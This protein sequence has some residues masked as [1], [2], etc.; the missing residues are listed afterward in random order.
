MS[1]GGTARV[2]LAALV[3]GALAGAGAVLL[4]SRGPERTPTPP[5]PL[6][7]EERSVIDT[8]RRVAPSVVYITTLDVRRDVFTLDVTAVPR[9][10]GSGFV[11]DA[12]GHIVTNFHVVTSADA[13]QV[14]LA[15][16]TS[17]P[18]RIV[19]LAPDV[20]LAV[21]RID[22]PRE[23]LSPIL[24]GTSQDLQVGQRALAI[25]NP[26]GLDHSLTVGVISALERTIESVTGREIPGVV[27]TDASINPGNSGGPLLD[28]AGRLI[29]VSTA[30]QSPSG[31]SA[32]I[33]FAVPVDTVR[34]VVPQLIEHGRVIRPRIGLRVAGDS[35]N[36][37][38]GLEGL[39]VLA[40][41]P[42]GPADRAGILGSGRDRRGRIILGDELLALGGQAL[43][44]ADHLTL[45]LEAHDVGA[46][47]SVRLRRGGDVR[48]VELTLAAP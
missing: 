40:V 13:L 9:G 34:R 46:T 15:D 8:F 27:Q 12:S 18:A 1:R 35:L 19:G 43:R 6:G 45:A 36:R 10:T 3:V 5:V 47:V 22:A 14:T 24:V 2:G 41:E 7:A 32:G 28:S 23:R 37:R 42:G 25:G 38:L 16:Q 39:L 26:F 17:H 20:D 33:G 44:T 48:E 11:W 30:I 21:L 29:G 4:S 31:A